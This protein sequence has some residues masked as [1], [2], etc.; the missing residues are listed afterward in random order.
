MND[1]FLEFK[2]FSGLK[3]YWFPMLV[4]QKT[5]G[6]AADIRESVK[7]GLEEQFQNVEANDP[8]IYQKGLNS[9]YLDAY[10][11][12]NFRGKVQSITEFRG[13]YTY[14]NPAVGC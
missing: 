1:Y 8:R 11:N 14:F 12:N 13:Q 6:E 4:T 10:I 5:T 3:E 7:N 9:S 2:F